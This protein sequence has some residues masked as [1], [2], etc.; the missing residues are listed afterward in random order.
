MKLAP[1]QPDE[2]LQNDRLQGAEATDVVLEENSVIITF[3]SNPTPTVNPACSCVSVVSV[4]PDGRAVF[5]V[6]PLGRD[7]LCALPRPA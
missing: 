1:I 3:K 5:T 7:V 6:S 2:C 4:A